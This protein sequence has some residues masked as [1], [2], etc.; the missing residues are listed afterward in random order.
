MAV[1]SKLCPVPGVPNPKQKDQSG[2]RGHRT[3][4]VSQL[5][6]H[7]IRHQKLHR[8]ERDPANRYGWQNT[9]QTF[10]PVHQSDQVDRHQNRDWSTKTAHC[11]AESIDRQARGYRQ[12]DHRDPDGAEGHRRCVRQQANRSGVERRKAQPGEHRGGHR[13][14]RARPS[15]PF[16][17]GPE[18]KGDE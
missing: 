8:R 4:Y 16:Y 15:G 13:H 11:R 14:W 9:S 10:P 12:R 3:E 1:R 5:R 6:P 2:D 18:G 17:E 7:E